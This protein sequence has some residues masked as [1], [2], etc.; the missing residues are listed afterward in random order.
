MKKRFLDDV[1]NISELDTT[2]WV[3]KAYTECGV[4]FIETGYNR[5]CVLHTR[6]RALTHEM[7]ASI[8]S[9]IDAKMASPYKGSQAILS[10]LLEVVDLKVD[11]SIANLLSS[12]SLHK[13]TPCENCPRKMKQA[14]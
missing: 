9:L 10:E 8:D 1:K 14:A 13:D 11:N 6:K 4:Y 12:C 3:I 7:M 2:G 5:C